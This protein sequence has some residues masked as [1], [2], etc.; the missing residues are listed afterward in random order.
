MIK[1][2]AFV[3][4]GCANIDIDHPVCSMIIQLLLFVSMFVSLFVCFP[5]LPH[6][7][8]PLG[9]I[10]ISVVYPKGRTH[11]AYTLHVRNNPGETEGEWKGRRAPEERGGTASRYNKIFKNYNNCFWFRNNWVQ[12][13]GGVVSWH[14]FSVA[15]INN[16]YMVLHGVKQRN[17]LK[18]S[19]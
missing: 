17:P 6:R 7:T 15:A 3:V 10:H 2:S 18:W 4:S 19:Y 13:W 5:K 16:H 1:H 11:I 9:F 12:Y 8:E 14:W